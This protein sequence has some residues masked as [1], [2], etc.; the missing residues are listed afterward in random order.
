MSTGFKKYWVMTPV[1]LGLCV[2]ERDAVTSYLIP[3]KVHDVQVAR[4]QGRVYS[5]YSEQIRPAKFLGEFVSWD[6]W[7]AGSVWPAAYAH[8]FGP[9]AVVLA[10]TETPWALLGLLAPVAMW[11]GAWMNFKGY[12][13]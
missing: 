9:A 12:W 3:N 11:V 10:C 13:R 8:G 4:Y 2:D 1:G 6:N 7:G 5:F